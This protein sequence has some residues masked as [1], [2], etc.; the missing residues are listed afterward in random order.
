MPARTAQSDK[1]RE[2][3]RPLFLSA[4]ASA[5]SCAVARTNSTPPCSPGER[6]HGSCIAGPFLHSPPAPP[7]PS[8]A[9]ALPY[10]SQDEAG[11]P[12]DSALEGP[13]L[14]ISPLLLISPAPGAVRDSHAGAERAER[15]CEHK[16]ERAA[17]R[18][19][20]C[21]LPPWPAA[22]R[23]PPAL[24]LSGTPRHPP[25]PSLPAAPLQLVGWTL[26][27][28]QLAAALLGLFGKEA[29]RVLWSVAAGLLNWAQ[30]PLNYYQLGQARQGAG[31]VQAG[32]HRLM[33]GRRS[34]AGGSLFR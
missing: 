15:V 24:S 13:G 14:R 30:W 17:S 28:L 21:P 34:G 22:P 18:S 23:R 1:G 4:R 27:A 2:G 20:F 25:P 10:L 8:R 12:L 29:L 31:R 7:S 3:S 33:A 16:G 11:A 19:G 5:Q 9:A 26:R 6:W 32:A